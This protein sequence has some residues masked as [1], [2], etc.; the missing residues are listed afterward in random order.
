MDVFDTIGE[1]KPLREVA[2]EW[3]AADIDQNISSGRAGRASWANED[4]NF[5]QSIKFVI[6]CHAELQMYI[7]QGDQ[8]ASAT[9][10]KVLEAAIQQVAGVEGGLEDLLALR[11]DRALLLLEAL[12][13]VSASSRARWNS[14]SELATVS[15]PHFGAA[16]S[17]TRRHP[18]LDQIGTSEPAAPSISVSRRRSSIAGRDTQVRWLRRRV[19]GLAQWTNDRGEE[20][21]SRYCRP[22]CSQSTML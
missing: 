8:T 18:S 16:P 7:H 9:T 22:F 2:D 5:E 6:N 13:S 19:P 14:L 4:Q 20:T 21:T 15:R 3:R 11:G 10:A 12:Q 17:P 1:S